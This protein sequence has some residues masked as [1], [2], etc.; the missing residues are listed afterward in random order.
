MKPTRNNRG[1]AHENGSIE[2]ANGHLKNAPVQRLHVDNAREW[3]RMRR[4]VVK[5]EFTHGEDNP[6][7]VVTSLGRSRSEAQL[8]GKGPTFGQ[9]CAL[10]R[11][12]S[13]LPAGPGG[14]AAR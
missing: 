7:F 10:R 2:S 14:R 1:V 11:S 6:C 5:A 13:H 4:V 8:F 9:V 12:S 3:S